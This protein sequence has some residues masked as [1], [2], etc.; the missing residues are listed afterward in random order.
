M[1][2]QDFVDLHLLRADEHH[3]IQ[4]ARALARIRG[5][6]AREALVV[7]S[8]QSP[9]LSD[10]V[11]RAI[12]EALKGIDSGASGPIDGFVGIWNNEDVN[13]RSWTKLELRAN[14]ENMFV[15]IWGACQPSDCDDGEWATPLSDAL[16][17]AILLKADHRFAIRYLTL[18]LA[19]NR[20]MQVRTQTHYV[21]GS[22]RP[23]D[24]RKDT[25]IKHLEPSPQRSATVKP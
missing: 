21:D 13:T 1:R 17:G 11:V 6:E 23:D 24:D 4:A 12:D 3:R 9:S 18:R 14:V 10:S 15:Q 8:R 2:E 25:F 20:R 19:A 7:A 16:D 22:G 5:A